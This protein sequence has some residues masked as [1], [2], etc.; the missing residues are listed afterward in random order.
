MSIENEEQ[1]EHIFPLI[2]EGESSTPRV[3]YESSECGDIPFT[4][5]STVLFIASE[6]TPSGYAYSAPMDVDEQGKQ[7]AV[8]WLCPG[9]GLVCQFA[10]GVVLLVGRHPVKCLLAHYWREL[11]GSIR[12]FVFWVSEADETGTPE[13]DS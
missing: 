9:G 10:D 4:V 6:Y 13:S 5:S 11:K 8:D 7:F 12:Q 2:E 3:V 1:Q